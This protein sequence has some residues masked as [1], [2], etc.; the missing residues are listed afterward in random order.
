MAFYGVKIPMAGHLYVEMEADSEEE[1]IDKAKHL[2]LSSDHL[3]YWETVDQFTKGNVCY[4][5]HPWEIEAEPIE[6]ED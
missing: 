1:A 3:E 6:S 4:C 2:D 5:P